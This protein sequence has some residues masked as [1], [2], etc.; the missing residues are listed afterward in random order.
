MIDEIDRLMIQ[1]GYSGYGSI[2]KLGDIVQ[3]HCSAD[4]LIK[5]QNWGQGIQTELNRKW[6]V[7][8]I[9]LKN[10]IIHFRD[11]QNSNIMG[12]VT[13]SKFDEYMTLVTLSKFDE[14][15]TLSDMRE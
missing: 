9:D 14:Y 5:E 8:Q 10:D 3:F 11:L 1:I 2:P 13:L 12:S 7:D 6:K 4:K 15:M